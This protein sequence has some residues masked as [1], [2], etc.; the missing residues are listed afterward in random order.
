MDSRRESKSLLLKIDEDLYNEFR[1]LAELK[2][3][4]VKGALSIEGTNAIRDWISK[5]R[6]TIEENAKILESIT[7]R[8]VR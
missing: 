2:N 7:D 3:H 6:E 1:R 8:E 4:N 5:N